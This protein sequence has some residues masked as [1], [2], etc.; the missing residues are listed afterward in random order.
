MPTLVGHVGNSTTSPPEATVWNHS[1]QEI[2]SIIQ[3]SRL[4]LCVLSHSAMGI[5]STLAT[6]IAGV[7]STRN[8]HSAVSRHTNV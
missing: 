8:H 4:Q 1:P 5:A 3:S 7:M 6:L 2:H